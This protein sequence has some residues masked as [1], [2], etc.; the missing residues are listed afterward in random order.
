VLPPWLLKK[1]SPPLGQV[2]TLQEH[3]KEQ[4]VGVKADIDSGRVKENSRRTL[5]HHL[6]TPNPEEGYVVPSIDDIK[7]EAYG[8]LAAAAD[9]T[10]NGMTV[11]TYHVVNN[12]MIYKKLVAELKAAFP[13]SNARLDFQVLEKL[14]YLTGVVKEGLRL[15]FGVIGRMP[16]IV[17]EGGATYNGYTVPAGTAVS[18]SSWMLHQDENYFPNALEFNPGR[19]ANIADVRR[20]EK[21]FVP[22]G[23][24]SRICVGMLL[25]YCEL[26]VTIGTLFR[27][28][29]N[30]RGNELSA[31]DLVY[32]DYFAS[33]HPI[34][35]KKFH[36]LPPEQKV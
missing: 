17:P 10:G 36:V 32:D 20:M 11:A 35:S 23:K 26:Y 15:S 12:P 30:L 8:I 14:P 18:M 24:G 6:L 5:F 16:R 3:A 4:V 21:A 2:L 34:E 33:H 7:D 1:M 31:E 28:F 19:W 9:T 22:F 27:R 25:A 13:D 29:E